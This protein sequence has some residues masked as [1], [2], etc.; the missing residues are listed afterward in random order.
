MKF[1]SLKSKKKLRMCKELDGGKKS[2]MKNKG[3]YSESL[4][5]EVFKNGKLLSS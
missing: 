3:S 2:L 4:W 5:A 1:I